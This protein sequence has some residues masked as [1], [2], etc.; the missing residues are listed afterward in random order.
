MQTALVVVIV[1]VAAIF[2]GR[3]LFN[4]VKKGGQA[5][6]GCGCS[7]CG[8]GSESQKNCDIQQNVK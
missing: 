3:R 5:T 7:G 4:S 6:C 8:C 2:L 1:A